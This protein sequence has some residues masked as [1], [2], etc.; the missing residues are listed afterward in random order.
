MLEKR[1]SP[2]VQE[3]NDLAKRRAPRQDPVS[4]QSCRKKKL[5]CDRLQ[6][7]SSCRSRRIP[8]KYAVANVAHQYVPPPM[9]S[10]PAVAATGIPSSTNNSITTTAQPQVYRAPEVQINSQDATE[11]ERSTDWLENIMMAPR[12]PDALPMSIKNKLIT[13]NHS[14]VPVTNLTSFLPRESEALTQ[15]KY[16]VDYVGYLYHAIIPSQ[17]QSHI[18]AIY[19]SMHYVSSA[20]ASSFPSAA[21]N[22]NH[23]ALLFSIL[24]A[25]FY[26]QNL[27]ADAA[28][29][30]QVEER[31]HEYITLVAAALMQSDYMNYPTVEGLQAA[32]VV[33]MI[34]PNDGQDTSVRALFHIGALVNQCRQMG[35]FQI[36]SAQNKAFRRKHGYDPMEV[37]LKRRLVWLVVSSDWF[38][39]FLGGPQEGSYL[40]NPAHMALD[41]P[42][43]I[44]DEDLCAG[45]GPVSDN[46][47][48][49]MSYFI[50]RL[51]LATYCR[52]IVDY[53]CRERLE[54]VDIPYSKIMELDQKWHEYN[55][56]LPEFFRLDANTR[57]KYA[58]LYASSPQIAWQRLLLQQGHHSRLCRLHRSY[59]IRGAKDPAYSYS[60]MMC[61]QAARRVIEIK[62]MM[63]K[64][65][66]NTPSVSTTWSVMHHVFMAVIILLMDVCFNWDDILADRRKE[67]IMEACRMLDKAQRNSRLVREGINAMTEVLQ[68]RCR[69]VSS[70]HLPLSQ[71]TEYPVHQG[72]V[73]QS[74]QEIEN[75]GALRRTE[76]G[77]SS[78]ALYPSIDV[79]NNASFAINATED[80]CDLENMWS[81]FLDNGSMMG[82]SPNEWMGLL[83]DL[84]ETAP[85]V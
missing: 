42:I 1:R 34:L 9:A 32:L 75:T 48:T 16:Y 59:F 71:D 4:C 10:A 31:C 46:V 5:K 33:S 78:A 6:P 36:D 29:A 22:L 8:C 43:N 49:T 18:N 24:A 85:A 79:G 3:P 37:E 68:S 67:E 77:S 2:H 56:E 76:E 65:F 81:E 73:V 27:D 23:L 14:A 13:A 64:E 62:R 25:A 7:C 51:K 55:K 39:A 80:M 47:P 53:T 60:H 72:T 52:D 63:D 38:L 44:S 30:K 26:F 74:T 45:G 58:Q 69:S 20:P 12:V 19:Q 28:S 41:M 21:V 57:R 17:V 40:V 82:G 61:L 70:D 50:F 84:T 83:S 15:F 66:P 35:L 54:G 11:E